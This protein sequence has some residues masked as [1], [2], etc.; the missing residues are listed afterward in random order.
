MGITSTILEAGVGIT[1]EMDLLCMPQ[2][3]PQVA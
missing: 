3:R 1:D 2:R